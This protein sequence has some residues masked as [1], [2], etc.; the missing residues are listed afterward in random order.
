MV[1][2]AVSRAPTLVRCAIGMRLASEITQARPSLPDCSPPGLIAG[3]EARSAT[4]TTGRHTAPQ[5]KLRS[6]DVF[7]A[8]IYL[9]VLLFGETKTLLRVPRLRSEGWC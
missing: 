7:L 3:A 9:G 4:R 2:R 5:H 1:M 6:A 8:R